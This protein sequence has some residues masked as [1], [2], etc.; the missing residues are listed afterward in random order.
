MTTNPNPNVKKNTLPGL[1][2][3]AGLSDDQTQFLKA[4]KEHLQMLQGSLGQPKSRAVTMK[5]LEDAGLIKV[6]TL[7]RR[8]EIQK[9]LVASTDSVQTL[10]DSVA[11]S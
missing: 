11:A 4:V 7:N 9:T 1:Q 10:T 2:V 5:D 8:A 3:P 6:M